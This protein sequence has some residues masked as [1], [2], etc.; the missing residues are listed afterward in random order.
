MKDQDK[1][2]YFEVPRPQGT[3][4]C[5]DRACPCSE[6]EIPQGSGFLYISQELCNFR[7][8]C[9]TYSELLIKLQQMADSDKATQA[10]GAAGVVR[11]LAPGTSAPILMCKHAANLR[12]VNMN[13]AAA[14]AAHWW[15]T[16][17]VPLRPTPST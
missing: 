7:Q 2:R 1:D 14:D 4:R 12:G 5:S 11:F 15:K 17:L 6:I 16:G 3:A 9:L 8:D 13:L 10:T